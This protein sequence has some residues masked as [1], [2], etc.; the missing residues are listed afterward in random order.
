MK[1]ST[2]LI[3][4]MAILFASLTPGGSPAAAEKL[5][6]IRGSAITGNMSPFFIFCDTA[7]LFNGKRMLQDCGVY[8]TRSGTDPLLVYH[9]TTQTC[10]PYDQFI[11]HSTLTLPDFSTAGGVALVNTDMNSIC[12]MDQTIPTPPGPPIQNLVLRA[13]ANKVQLTWTAATG[14]VNYNI[15]RSTTNGGPY[16]LIKE[17]LVTTYATYL[18]SGLTYGTTYYY[19]VRWVNSLGVESLNSNQASV[20]PALLIR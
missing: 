4:M 2:I 20:T 1:L 16:Q 19:M 13:K 3:M 6:L 15:Y 12:T 10:E 7:A 11:T 14:A 17:G 9:L 8:N 18:D 5:I